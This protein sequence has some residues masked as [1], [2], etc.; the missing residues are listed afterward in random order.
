VAESASN[1]TTTE[2]TVINN[3]TGAIEGVYHPE[4]ESG[5]YSFILPSGCNNNITF[6]SPGKLFHSINRTLTDQ[7]DYFEKN[8]IVRLEPITKKSRTVLSNIFF[9]E[10]KELPQKFSDTELNNIYEFL[11]NNPTTYINLNNIIHS[12]DNKKFYKR[13]SKNR[14][15]AVK[16]I[17]VTKGI[18]EDR[19]SIT[20][21]RHP[22]PKKLPK[23]TTIPAQIMELEITEVK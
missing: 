22:F 5:S 16:D 10:N 6:K 3:E 13:L 8:T 12:K 2:I 9:E 14:A 7:K 11:K 1:H 21:I 4:P 17:L 15:K 18:R 23:D 20:G 19:I